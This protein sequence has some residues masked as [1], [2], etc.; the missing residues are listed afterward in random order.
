VFVKE[1]STFSSKW[2]PYQFEMND[3]RL[4]WTRQ[5]HHKEKTTLKCESCTLVLD[6]TVLSIPSAMQHKKNKPPS[7]F[8]LMLTCVGV[9]PLEQSLLELEKKEAMEAAKAAA[10]PS[11]S[12]SPAPSGPSTLDSTPD[13][14]TTL[15][16]K[17]VLTP[18]SK[19]R[20][21][22]NSA[23]KLDKS[24]KHKSISRKLGRKKK[25]YQTWSLASRKTQPS[26]LDSLS[27][28]AS[29]HDLSLISGKNGKHSKDRTYVFYFAT[30]EARK[31]FICCVDAR[32]TQVTELT[33]I[34]LSSEQKRLLA[35]EHAKPA[36]QLLTGLKRLDVYLQSTK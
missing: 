5:I 7:E 1:E 20:L 30:S 3:S 4:R 23:T 11:P 8:G 25:R 27:R 31:D 6:K 32:V 14:K 21:F 22:H 34:L 12:V 18:S 15:D 10:A 29:N 24:E 9:D 17:Q 26:P 2:Q 28:T 35:S 36:A 13:S 19:V 33:K 16:G